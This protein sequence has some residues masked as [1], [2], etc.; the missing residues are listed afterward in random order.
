VDRFA[1]Q[2]PEK[3]LDYFDWMCDPIRAYPVTLDRFKSLFL[4][5]VRMPDRR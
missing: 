1:E 5:Q 2:A 3:L 4:D